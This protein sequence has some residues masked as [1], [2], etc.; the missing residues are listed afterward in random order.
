MH[1]DGTLI[2]L[3]FIEM[4]PCMVSKAKLFIT[5]HELSSVIPSSP[6]SQ[7]GVNKC[8][9]TFTRVKL[10]CN[11]FHTPHMTLIKDQSTIH[12]GVKISL[13]SSSLIQTGVKSIFSI[14]TTLFWSF[15]ISPDEDLLFEVET[16][17]VK[18][19]CKFQCWRSE[20]NLRIWRI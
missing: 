2:L 1:F 9:N 16:S 11:S 19:L 3:Y 4:L 14:N 5:W 7:K 20:K 17:W 18:L 15:F 10:N 13:H 12:K 6:Y 8:G